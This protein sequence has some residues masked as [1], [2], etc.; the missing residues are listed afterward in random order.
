MIQIFFVHKHKHIYIYRFLARKKKKGFLCIAACT[1][2]GG[3]MYI[4]AFMYEGGRG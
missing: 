3:C 2:G 1:E 4:A